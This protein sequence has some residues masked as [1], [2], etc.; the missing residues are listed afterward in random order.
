MLPDFA[1]GDLTGSDDQ[2]SKVIDDAYDLVDGTVMTSDCPYAAPVRFLSKIL[3]PLQVLTFLLIIGGLIAYAP[4]ARGYAGD[5]V[6]VVDNK[7]TI[8]VTSSPGEQLNFGVKMPNAVSGLWASPTGLDLTIGKEKFQ[9]MAPKPQTWGDSI[10]TSR[11]NISDDETATGRYVVPDVTAETVLDGKI[12]GTVI[13]PVGGLGTFRDENTIVEVPIKLTVKPGDN[14]W[15]TGKK[16]TTLVNGILV[17]AGVLAFFAVLSIV[18]NAVR[19]GGAA[20]KEAFGALFGV[21]VMTGFFVG[22]LFLGEALATPDV[23]DVDVLGALPVTPVQFIAC[24]GGAAFLVMFALTMSPDGPPANQPTPTP[25]TAPPTGPAAPQTG[26]GA[27]ATPPAGPATPPTGPGY[28]ATPPA[29]PAT[30]PTGS[31]AP[32]TPHAG[33]GAPPASGV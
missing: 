23:S 24:L 8:T 6:Y 13:H 14:G 25:P 11:R 7:Q 10:T 19:Y 18:K 22:A 21:L 9:L 31:S 5:H 20:W 15:T 16:L 30:P 33:P 2:P 26:P 32:A 28:P 27:P 29:G 4:L 17:A 1:L 3:W 12:S